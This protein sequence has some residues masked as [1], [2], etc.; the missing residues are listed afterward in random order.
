L[1]EL[2]MAK[3]TTS[4]W[5]GREADAWLSPVR[6]YVE[7][8]ARESLRLRV[9]RFLTPVGQW[10]ELHADPLTWSPTRPLT[11]YRPFAKSTTGVLLAGE[12]VIAGRDWGWATFWAPGVDLDGDL[13]EDE[14]NT[15]ARAAGGRVAMEVSPGLTVGGSIARLRRSLPPEEDAG[16][17]PQWSTRADAL[18]R[19]DPE[20]EEEAEGR[21]LVGADLRWESARAQL[22]LEGT[23]LRAAAEEVAEGGAFAR[24]AVRIGGPL[25]AVARVESYRP[26]DGRTA[27][28]GYV[29]L[30]ARPD[31]RLVVKLGRQFTR[32][33]STRIPD[34]WFLSF[35]SLF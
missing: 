30:T 20:R 26:I 17:G 27:D 5:T 23:W 13:E 8:S 28:V 21:T 2:D 14:E 6:L 11:T 9:G 29:G 22:A 35:S 25:W 19:D 7:L 32:R 12:G 15:F 4:T 10:N 24:L 33:P 3:R 31:R 1:V 16:G 34:G 18:R